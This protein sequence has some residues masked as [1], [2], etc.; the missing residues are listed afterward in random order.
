MEILVKAIVREHTALKTPNKGFQLCKITTQNRISSKK[1]EHLEK[2]Q[3][4][5][6]VLN[7][8]IALESPTAWF[9]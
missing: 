1:N 9:W 4:N 6:E 3:I 8:S 5:E 7:R 2:Q